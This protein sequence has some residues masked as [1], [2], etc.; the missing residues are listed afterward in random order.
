MKRTNKQ[1]GKAFQKHMVGK[2]I[3]FKIRGKE[4]SSL[5]G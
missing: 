3:D 5:V 4:S 2:L 1:K